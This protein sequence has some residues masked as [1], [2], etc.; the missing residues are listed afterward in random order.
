MGEN[1]R[2]IIAIDF[3][4]QLFRCVEN[5]RTQKNTAKPTSLLD[6][7]SFYSWHKSSSNGPFFTQPLKKKMYDDL[8]LW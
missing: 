2:V 6:E 8:P 7:R 3:T 5:I 4:T 1:P